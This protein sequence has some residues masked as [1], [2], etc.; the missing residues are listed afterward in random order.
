MRE[1]AVERPQV[2]RL[3]QLLVLPVILLTWTYFNALPFN[4]DCAWLLDATR[5]WVGGQRLYVDIFE[6]NPP[7]IFVE[8]ILLTA[9]NLTKS[10][11]LAGVCIVIG[12]S[13]LW[14]GRPIP[15]L[16]AMIVAGWTDFGQRDH[17][18][19]IFLL[20][21]LMARSDG[22]ARGLWAFLGVALKPYFVAIPAAFVLAQCVKARSWRPVYARQNMA[23]VG[24]C[25]AYLVATA[26][27]WPVYFTDALPTAAFVYS[28]YGA[29]LKAIHIALAILA[30]LIF[31][32]VMEVRRDLLPLA[33]ATIGA[34]IAFFAQGRFW[35]YQMVP[36]VGLAIF[37]LMLAAPG[38]S[39]RI[40]IALSMVLAGVVGSK[41]VRDWPQQASVPIP[42]GIERVA[43]LSDNVWAAYPTVLERGIT[44]TSRFPALW[45]LPGAWNKMHDP[46]LTEQERVEAR[47]FYDR[48]ASKVRA[49]LN[50]G[51]PQ[52]IYVERFVKPDYYTTPL[53][54]EALIPAGYRKTGE[55]SG[56]DV[57]VPTVAHQ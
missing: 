25:L 12:I 46:E 42:P 34:V 28:A 36:T 41:L 53:P 15:A 9:G 5:R 35:S 54:F 8:N 56:F 20:P 38:Q 50:N 43:F 6:N 23:L 18:A 11:Y 29:S 48:E 19:L 49:D 37:T 10:A 45:T 27:I 40:Q 39:R 26:L 31:A 44:N 1:L 30:M 4:H 33:A 17:L 52:I 32:T 14:T 16:A 22:V 13:A 7:L 47:Q 57:W 2:R 51:K 55:V 21:Y 3:D 24:S